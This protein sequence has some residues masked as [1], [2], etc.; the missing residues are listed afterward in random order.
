MSMLKKNDASARQRLEKLYLF[1]SQHSDTHDD[2]GTNRVSRESFWRQA[3]PWQSLCLGMGI[4]T[5]A[6][7]LFSTIAMSLDGMSKMTLPAPLVYGMAQEHPISILNSIPGLS[8]DKSVI[9]GIVDPSS[10]SAVYYWSF[11]LSN[12]SSQAQEAQ[13]E[14]ALPA[15]AVV[16]RAT[17][18]IN[19]VPQEAAFSS[20]GR[21]TYAYEWITVHHRDPLLVTQIAPGRVMVKAAPVQ[22]GGPPMT[23]RIGI[24]APMGVDSAGQAK[25]MLPHIVASNTQINCRQ[26]VH[27][28]APTMLYSSEPSAKTVTTRQN[29]SVLKANVDVKNLNSLTVTT[30]STSV[31]KQFAT[32]ATHSSPPGYILTTLVA[33]KGTALHLPKF[34]KVLSRPNCRLISDE[35]V[36]HR[37]STLWAASEINHLATTGSIDQAVDL[38]NAYRVVSAVSGATVLETEQDYQRTSLN[39][40]SSRSL[41]YISGGTR[42]SWI[43]S[44]PAANSTANPFSSGEVGVQ[45]RSTPVT[46]SQTDT[47]NAGQ[48]PMLQGATSGTVGPQTVDAAVVSA[49]NTAG[50]VR[51]NSLA[52]F[53][54]AIRSAGSA[55]LIGSARDANL[56]GSE[57]SSPDNIIGQMLS[58]GAF[59][60]AIP[61]LTLG[62][63]FGL[64]FMIAFLTV[65]TFTGPATLL[66]EAFRLRERKDSLAL[67]SVIFSALWLVVAL[68]TPTISQLLLTVMVVQVLWKAKQSRRCAL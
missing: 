46:G 42:P 57:E 8:A 36:A 31:P 52:N 59:I 28:E 44:E 22:P 50:T 17:L 2:V 30:S 56:F 48:A 9:T 35:N 66:V 34:E 1:D 7:G 11:V 19:G 32:R 43:S 23:L 45:L 37:L 54:A 29:A 13:F 24:T 67:R 39:R 3:V 47:I 65:C 49:L 5:V 63:M 25:V 55:L 53:D 38:A 33:D 18:W 51:V 27:L 60:C 10:L 61:A 68:A 20:T 15:G 16:S 4:S 40:D 6:V 64:G 62:T 12:S 14:I 41:S 58:I 21:V 26:D